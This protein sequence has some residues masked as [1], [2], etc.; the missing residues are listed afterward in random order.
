MASE[1]KEAMLNDGVRVMDAPTCLLSGEQGE[2]V[3]RNLRDQLFHAPGEWNLRR[4]PRMPFLWLDPRPEKE[5]VGKLYSDY[6]THTPTSLSFLNRRNRHKWKLRQIVLAGCRNY[7]GAWW[8]R[9]VGGL[10][11]LAWFPRRMADQSVM[12][13]K[14]PT[15]R[16]LDIGCGNGRFLKK[17]EFMGWRVTGVE[18]DRA[19][20]D[21]ARQVGLEVHDGTIEEQDFQPDSFDAITMNHVIEH[22][23][24]PVATLK[25]CHRLLV[26][27]GQLLL[28]TPN[29]L[30]LGHARF[31]EDWRGLE[32][33]RHLFLFS[34]QALNH[35]VEQANMKVAMWR[36]ESRPAR[37]IMRESILIRKRREEPG[38]DP[39]ES[40]SE[41]LSGWL[42]RWWEAICCIF[43]PVG[44]EIVL[45]AQKPPQ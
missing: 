39:R 20:A 7:P 34:P 33:P 6:H 1:G 29:V 26:P 24:D 42:F 5:D 19:S 21:A 14:G 37:G 23:L 3:Y 27:G 41:R 18:P 4:S 12:W 43:S 30:S 10:L 8:E 35:C 22:V 38:G 28:V 40:L 25:A 17:M 13:L 15:G 36:T 45:V 31:R 9:I 11:S 32:V 16:L 44:E 2:L